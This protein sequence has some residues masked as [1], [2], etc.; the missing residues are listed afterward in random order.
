[1][2]A[3]ELRNFIFAELQRIFGQNV[4][5]GQNETYQNISF[6]FPENTLRNHDHSGNPISDKQWRVILEAEDHR[7][8]FGGSVRNENAIH[9]LLNLMN[10][11]I[12]IQNIGYGNNCF[13][14]YGI[15]ITNR[16]ELNRALYTIIIP[17]IYNVISQ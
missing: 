5:Q 8:W 16:E 7:I 9:T 1:M 10:Y 6:N 3:L 17:S 4:R 11:P 15:S 13:P 14:F 12:E 2:C